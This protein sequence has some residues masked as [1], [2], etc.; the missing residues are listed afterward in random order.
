[1]QP[2]TDAGHI[3]DHVLAE[4]TPQLHGSHVVLVG[5][6]EWQ[7]GGLLAQEMGDR[8]GIQAVALTGF[9]LRS[10]ALSGPLWRD[11]MDALTVL[12]QELGHAAA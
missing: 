2:I 9:T 1:V 5:Q 10:A 11:L 7:G 12:G 4:P 3:G 8:Q 6:D